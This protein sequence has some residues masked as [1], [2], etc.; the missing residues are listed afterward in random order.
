MAGIF[1]WLTLKMFSDIAG[2]PLVFSL[3]IGIFEGARLTGN[4]GFCPKKNV[5]HEMENVPTFG[6]IFPNMTRRPDFLGVLFVVF[7]STLHSLLLM[8]STVSR[9]PHPISQPPAH[10]ASVFHHIVY[11]SVS[12]RLYHCRQ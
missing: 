4:A 8:L 7:L 1:L 6:E 9:V 2:H 3:E 11:V 12:F 10:V 5:L